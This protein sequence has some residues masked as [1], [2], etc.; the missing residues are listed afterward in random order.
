MNDSEKLQEWRATINNAIDDIRRQRNKIYS[1]L[2]IITVIEDQLKDTAMAIEIE[3]IE[4]NER[5]MQE[6]HDTEKKAAEGE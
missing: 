4:F 2:T 6:D 5:V 1:A 3:Q